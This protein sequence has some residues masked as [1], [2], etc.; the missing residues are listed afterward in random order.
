MSKKKK[1]FSGKY[2]VSKDN[3]CH[4]YLIPLE[5]RD[6]WEDFLELPEDDEESWSTPSWAYGFDGEF[7]SF[8]NPE[9]T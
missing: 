7:L 5:N 1:T 6:Q 3:D 4:N 2:F 8:E 9:L